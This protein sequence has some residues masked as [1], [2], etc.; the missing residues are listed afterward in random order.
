MPVES[1]APCWAR[2]IEIIKDTKCPKCGETARFVL[3]TYQGKREVFISANGYNLGRVVWFS[4]PIQGK[5]LELE[6]GGGHRWET[7]EEGKEE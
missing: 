1:C 7:K 4:K 5:K 6:C 3:G 2:R